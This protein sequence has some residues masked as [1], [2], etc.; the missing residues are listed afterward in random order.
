MTSRNVVPFGLQIKAKS[1]NSS[2]ILSLKLEVRFSKCWFFDKKK[3][4]YRNCE[5]ANVASKINK[6]PIKCFYKR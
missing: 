1:H 6:Y 4:E 5:R 2:F 3:L